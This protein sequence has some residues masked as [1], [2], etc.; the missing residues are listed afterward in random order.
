MAPAV[1]DPDAVGRLEIVAHVNVGRA[2]A[3]DVAEHDRQSQVARR[4]AQR[5]AV[6][7][8]KRAVRPGDR[9]ELALA[10]IQIEHVRRAQFDQLAGDD[11]VA[12]RVTTGDDIVGLRTLRTEIS[13]PLRRI[14]FSPLFAM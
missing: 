8:E 12:L 6:G 7:C 14:E 13:P 5:M 11:F 9:S 2:V 10:V 3:V 1:V 4:V